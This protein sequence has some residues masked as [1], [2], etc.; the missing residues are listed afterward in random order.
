VKPGEGR[1]EEEEKW[2]NGEMEN[3]KGSDLNYRI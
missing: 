2:R 3:F 1:R